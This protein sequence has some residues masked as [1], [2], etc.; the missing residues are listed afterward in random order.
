MFSRLHPNPPQSE[1]TLLQP[2]FAGVLSLPTH[3]LFSRVPPRLSCH[4]YKEPPTYLPTENNSKH[5]KRKPELSRYF[6]HHRFP[7]H[8]QCNPTPRS[9]PK[10]KN[11]TNP[12]AFDTSKFPLGWIYPAAMHK[13]F[14]ITANYPP[15]SSSCL[16]LPTNPNTWY[17]HQTSTTDS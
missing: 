8:H 14:P 5:V 15:S 9:P 13:V 6:F 11:R 16:K 2:C 7:K 17:H 1:R 10:Y 12:K 3:W 4:N